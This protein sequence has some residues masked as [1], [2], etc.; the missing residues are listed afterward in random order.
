[1]SLMSAL[2]C[3]PPANSVIATPRT[4]SPYWPVRGEAI[5][6]AYIP[7]VRRDRAPVQRNSLLTGKFSPREP[8]YSWQPIGNARVCR[9]QWHNRREF[10][11]R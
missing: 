11:A 3:F 10:S 6:T 5:W 7:I 4:A 8:H 2:P 1:V 9:A